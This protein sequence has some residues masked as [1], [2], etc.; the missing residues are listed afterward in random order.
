MARR[1]SSV[2]KNKKVVPTPPG[3][4]EKLQQLRSFVDQ[5]CSEQDLEGCLKEC[6]CDVNLAAMKLM[7][8]EYK[9][10]R[11]TQKRAPSVLLDLTGNVQSERNNTKKQKS[12]QVVA[13]APKPAPKPSAGSNLEDEKTTDYLLVS[14]WINGDSRSKGGQVSYQEKLEFTCSQSGPLL[15]RWQ[16]N[17]VAGT[18]PQNLCNILAPLLRQRHI[19]LSA[20]ILME[21]TRIVMGTQIP[22]SLSIFILDPHSFFKIFDAEYNDTGSARNAY[23][24]NRFKKNA[25]S[26]NP[27]DNISQAAFNLLQWAQYGDDPQF[28]R[29]DDM[30]NATNESQQDLESDE[31]PLLEESAFEEEQESRA[32]EWANDV[33]KEASKDPLEN[34]AEMPDPSGLKSIILR[35]YQR[36]ALSW[37][38]K[39][40]ADT[41]NRDDLEKEL[42]LLSELART[43]EGQTLNPLDVYSRG[44]GST[45]EIS[46]ECGPVLVSAAGAAKSET[47]DGVVNP[48]S[49]P[50]WQRRYLAYNNMK[51]SISFF[52]NE[53]LGVATSQPPLPPRQCVGGIEADAMGLGKTVMLLAL[54]LKSKNEE[55]ARL[56]TGGYKTT[57]VVAPLSLIAQWEEELTSKTTLKHK[58]FY[59]DSKFAVYNRTFDGVDVVVTTYGSLQAE[60]H[61]ISKRNARNDGLLSYEWFRVIL[62]EAHCIKNAN[63]LCSKACC[64]LQAERRWCVTGTPIQNSLQ[65]VYALLKFLQHEPWCENGFWKA[66]IPSISND[67]KAEGEETKSQIALDRVRRVLSP[68]ILR[69]SK[70]T[71]NSDGVP[72]LTLPPM[73]VKT[74]DVHLSDPEREFYN[75]LKF[76][77]R[78][79]FEGIVKQGSFTKSYFQIFALLNRLRQ[80]C[81]HVALTVRNHIEDANWKPT[82][83]S[84]D[85]A[86]D[87]VKDPVGTTDLVDNSF[88]EGLLQK[89]RMKQVSATEV[90]KNGIS[91]EFIK[92]VATQISQAVSL[93]RESIDDECAICLENI[94]INNAVITP[95]AHVFCSQCLVQILSSACSTKCNVSAQIPFSCPDGECPECR[96]HIEA[97][98]IISLSQKDDKVETTFLIENSSKP[99]ESLYDEAGA[100]TTL[101]NALNGENSAKLKAIIEELGKIW[102]HDPRS[103]VLIFSQFLGFLDLLELALR[104]QG[105]PF[106]RLDGKLSLSKRNEVI[107]TFKKQ[108]NCYEDN[109]GSVLLMSMKAGGVGLNL[110]QASSVFIV[111]PWW[112]AAVEDQCIMRCHRIGQTAPVVRVRKFCV[113]DSVEERIVS[114]QKRKKNMAGQVL[115][116]SDKGNLQNS[117][118]ATMEDFKLLF[119]LQ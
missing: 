65:D 16:G 48:V 118:K 41:S 53:L 91:E 72:I 46:C 101:E 22:L 18:L 62:D 34:V 95:C 97:K 8:G 6:G 29:P 117:S 20:E 60:F 28:Q 94:R 52:V 68:L 116:Q 35:P 83:L 24:G 38:W 115:S 44:D 87:S 32:E 66:A 21:E 9:P 111:D 85:V 89:F 75:S 42:T 23:F 93:K 47:V 5:S 27:A 49:H 106:G 81:D 11:S 88:L 78:T 58:I 19:R 119:G 55:N 56:S 30:Q 99:E 114:L 63:T 1:H 36:Q 61:A 98:K 109:R 37:M 71:L 51:S 7:T 69:R 104:Q 67:K 74:I 33:V 107:E 96:E 59:G 25:N 113:K 50:L 73:D 76:R 31:E 45:T 10:M 79:I 13:R 112:N 70:D 102:V 39:R 64:M 12:S 100:R 54:I 86:S 4:L 90:K 84:T 14:R 82:N 103:K 105:I 15:V 40:E 2:S 17:S 110:V 26:K 57:L 80:A 108:T 77:S 3:F 43:K 92:K